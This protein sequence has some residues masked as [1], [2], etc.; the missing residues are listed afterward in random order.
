MAM[1]ERGRP[2][3]LF[4]ARRRRRGPLLLLGLALVAAAAALWWTRAHERVLEPAPAPAE[5]PLAAPAPLGEA[6]PPDELAEPAPERVPAPEAPP[7]EPLPPLA[8]SDALARETGAA[9]SSHPLA[10]AVL[11]ETGVIER[12][13][14]AVDQ[15]AEGVVPRRDFEMLRPEGR[16]L[17]LGG[18][19]SPRIDPASYRRYD[20]LAAAVA[21]LDAKAVAA[22][23]R[24]LAPL[25]EEAYRALGYPEGGFEARLRTALALLAATPR[26]DAS[27]ALV[28]EVKRFEFRDSELEALADAQKQLLRTGPDNVARITAKLREIEASL[29]ATQAASSEAPR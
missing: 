1:N 19:A 12:L 8:E 23:Y 11:R 2:G 13:V 25:C 20:A 27:P 10:A 6:A 22:A 7:S 29:D 17:V 9:L 16:F 28:A 5:E 21:A 4:R 24:R 18:D 26:I 3:S 15:L 14:A